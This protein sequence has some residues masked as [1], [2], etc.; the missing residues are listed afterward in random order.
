MQNPLKL[1]RKDVFSFAAIVIVALLVGLLIN[2]F[3][4]KPLPIAYASKQERLDRA[5]AEIARTS[6][7]P[8]PPG[9]VLPDMLTLAQFSDFVEN[10]RG[11]ILDARYRIEHQ[12]A[13]VPGALS[14]PRDEFAEAYAALKGQLDRARPIVIYCD[15]KDCEDSKLVQKALRDLGYGQVAVFKGGWAEWTA[16]RKPKEAN[17]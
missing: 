12:L 2:R 10:R 14:L 17:R 16:A 5:V 11:T 4:E 3:R 13:H 6:Q 9:P 8:A 7:R 15:G 1:L